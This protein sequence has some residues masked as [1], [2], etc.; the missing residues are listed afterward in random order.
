MT[1][2]K[3]KTVK[4]WKS[5]F[6]I[7]GNYNNHIFL[8]NDQNKIMAPFNFFHLPACYATEHKTSLVDAA[9]VIKYPGKDTIGQ[10]YRMENKWHDGICD[11]ST[12]KIRCKKDGSSFNSDYGPSFGNGDIVR[13]YDNFRAGKK[14]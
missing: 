10:W 2:V 4:T 12:C 13:C 14:R 6:R 7:K 3:R 1:I 11:D 9:C 8:D 5:E